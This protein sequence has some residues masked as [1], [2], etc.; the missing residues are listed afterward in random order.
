MALVASLA[1]ALLF[2]HLF[3]KLTFP[4]DGFSFE[5]AARLNWP[6]RTRLLVPPLGE[7]RAPTHAGPLTF[8]ITLWS[9]DLEAVRRLLSY[10]AEPGPVSGAE[11][12][13][14]PPRDGQQGGRR[15]TFDLASTLAEQAREA[16]RWLALRVAALGVGGGILG[17]VWL[18][19]FR[20]ARRWLLGGAVGLGASAA[21]LLPAYVTYDTA[22]FARAE[23]RGIIETAP[24]MLEAAR[25]GLGRLDVLGRRLGA[26]AANLYALFDGIDHLGDL[27]LPPADL[28]VLHVSD[29]HNNPAAFDFI[30]SIARRFGADVIIDTGDLT[31]WATPLEAD[32]LRRIGSL[33]LPYVV[34][35]GNH[36]S[37][38]IVERLRATPHVRVLQDELVTIMGLRIYGF[39]DPASQRPS[40]QPPTAKEAAEEGAR[41]AATLAELEEPVHLV[42]VHNHRIAAQLPDGVAQAVLF[43][44]NHRLAL[45][46]SGKTVRINAGTTG[47]AGIRGLQAHE[48]V[49]YSLA[50]L[51]FSRRTEE[52]SDEVPSSIAPLTDGP[53]GDGEAAGNAETAGD[54]E[55]NGDGGTAKDGDGNG[56][57]ADSAD[58]ASDRGPTPTRRDG[59]SLRLAVVDTIQVF[60]LPVRSLALERFALDAPSPEDAMTP[61]NA[62][63]PTEPGSL[64]AESKTDA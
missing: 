34:V 56:R 54:G 24:W 12:R 51:Y 58:D 17:S 32:L 61:P 25:D 44:H 38:L 31:D 42:A 11:E 55:G 14:A 27:G 15:D 9:V 63:G 36:E 59:D 39:A 16:A 8:H 49:P 10:A 47:A 28:V 43:G 33:G 60:T 13:G 20:P 30:E 29:I 4:V 22:A 26:I 41:I 18:L 2:I 3:A 64:D 40:P 23:Y 52:S 53:A 57:G 6:P 7:I 19:G 5:A 50:I 35:P 45:D 48:P 62:D 46:V 21:V 1:V 37:P